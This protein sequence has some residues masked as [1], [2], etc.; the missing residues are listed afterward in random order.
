M[1]EK[2]LGVLAYK[3][4]TRYQCALL[5]KKANSVLGCIT[6][7][8]GCRLREMIVPLFSALVRHLGRLDSFLGF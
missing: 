7:S 8:V 3:M 2:D 1:V 4:N 5:A 6:K